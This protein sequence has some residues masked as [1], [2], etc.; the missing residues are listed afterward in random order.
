MMTGHNITF[1]KLE[2]AEARTNASKIKGPARVV[3][4]GKQ[5]MPR[6]KCLGK[7]KV[8]TGSVFENL[9]VAK[10]SNHS[11]KVMAFCAIVRTPLRSEILPCT[12]S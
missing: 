3:A 4:S 6:E 12:F 10:C 7:V 1:D 8:R 9:A 5:Y 11:N 2:P